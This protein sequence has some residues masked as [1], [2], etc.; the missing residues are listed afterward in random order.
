[1]NSSDFMIY[2][3]LGDTIERIE[4][5]Q[6]SNNPYYLTAGG[7]DGKIY[8]WSIGLQQS[9][10]RHAFSIDK[11]NEIPEYDV[12]STQQI[13]S[14]NLEEPIFSLCWKRNTNSILVGTAEG[15]LLHIDLESNRSDKLNQ[16]DTGIREILHY[17]DD[18]FDLI[19]TGNYDGIIRLWDSR[20]F[21]TPKAS[22][23]TNN[24]IYS[25]SLDNH[26]LLV[27]MHYG[28]ICYFNLQKL[29]IGVFQPEIIF[30]S[31]FNQMLPIYSICAFPN[32]EGFACTC[33]EGK[34]SVVFSDFN[35]PPKHA[36]ES[37]KLE[38]NQNNFV[39]RT[40]RK[41]DPR[42]NSDSYFISQLKTNKVY[43][44]FASCGGDGNLF[45][46]DYVSRTRLKMINFPGNPPIT[47]MNFSVD[48]NI[49][50]YACGDDWSE[51]HAL[52]KKIE[53]KIALRYLSNIEK[54][55]KGLDKK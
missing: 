3:K 13:V 20:D 15:T 33:L 11:Q 1:M 50:A 29:R 42:D 23:D 38:S 22:Y 51:G 39:F 52:G 10:N 31:N 5:S 47:A 17:Q 41:T 36:K 6:N 18:S 46:W 40:H 28:L 48:G 25:M 55:K 44:S 27:G 8:L 37:K 16:L 34:V 9:K 21:S 30:E 12:V 35:A 45:I 32:L 54:M 2:D 24:C 19:I 14:S 43:G 49:I 26:I 4:F 7:W 53:T